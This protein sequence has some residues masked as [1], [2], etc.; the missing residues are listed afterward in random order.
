MIFGLLYEQQ[1]VSACDSSF[2]SERGFPAGQTIHVETGLF[3]NLGQPN[4][5]YTIARMST[6]PHGN[7]LLAL[8]SSSE[9]GNSGTDFFSPA[10]SIPTL[11][12]GGRITRLGYSDQIIGLPV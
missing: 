7:S 2:C 1:I 3:L 5:G 11:L 10:S 12:N 4:G 6:I 8:G 9:V